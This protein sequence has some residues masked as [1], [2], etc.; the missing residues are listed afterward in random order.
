MLKIIVNKNPSWLP[1]SLKLVAFY[2]GGSKSPSCEHWW[3]HSS[4]FPMSGFLWRCPS[5]YADDSLLSVSVLFVFISYSFLPLLYFLSFVL[6]KALGCTWRKKRW[7]NNVWTIHRGPLKHTH[8]THTGIYL[9]SLT[10]WFYIMRVSLKQSVNQSHTNSQ[11]S[12]VAI[13]DGVDA[14]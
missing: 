4:R 7:V 1:F 5:C 9:F 2:S 14:R 3:E 8:T 13:S 10:H 6:R 12:L 11:G